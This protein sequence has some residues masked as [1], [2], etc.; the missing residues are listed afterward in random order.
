[1]SH[2][3]LTTCALVETGPVSGIDINPRRPVTLPVVTGK[4]GSTSDLLI[5]M[6]QI[7]GD[8]VEQVLEQA[9]AEIR[10]MLEMARDNA[11]TQTPTS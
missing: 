6:R 5:T 9:T 3:I 1:M 4:D 10:L 11:T 8:S 7:H 2:F